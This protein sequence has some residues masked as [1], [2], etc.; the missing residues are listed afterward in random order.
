MIMVNTDVEF[1]EFVQRL[2]DKFGFRK[3]LKCKVK[4]EDGDGFINISDQEDLDM[5]IATSKKSAKRDR[6][7]M[8]KMEVSCFDSTLVYFSYKR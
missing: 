6:V 4:D 1:D 3:K 7:E 5:V 2:K 8:G